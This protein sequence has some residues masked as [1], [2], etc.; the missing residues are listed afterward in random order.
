MRIDPILLLLAVSS[1]SAILPLGLGVFKWKHLS[2]KLKILSAY[3]LL[4][5]LTDIVTLQLAIN[6]INNLSLLY[7]FTVLEFSLFSTIYHKIYRS[8][9]LKRI[10]IIIAMF[11]LGLVIVN[12]YKEG[13]GSYA[14]APRTVES[15]IFT[16]YSI[17]YF[18]QILSGSFVFKVEKDAMFWF[19]GSILV[20]FAGLLLFFSLSSYILEHA[21]IDM[22]RILFTT[23]AI[24]NIVQKLLFTIAIWVSQ[25]KK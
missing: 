1:Y 5:L 20:Y 3:L 25:R 24:L 11:F 17:I 14:T 13:I 7:V 9:R 16:T 6:S 8:L 18:Y 10:I 23:P 22:Q 21:S 12:L 15:I 19:N 4:S 2:F